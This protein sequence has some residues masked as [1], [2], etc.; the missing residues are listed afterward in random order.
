M[1]CLECHAR[2]ERLDSEHLLGCCGLTL[3]EYALR[4]HRP[5]ELLLAPDQVGA[6]DDPAAWTGP[7]APPREHARA[8]LQGLR[9]AGLLRTEGAFAVIPG[10]VRR[11]DLL[12]W[13]LAWLRDF[14][15]RF[16]QEYHYEGHR[17]MARNRL[18]APAANLRR[19]RAVQLSPVPPPGFRDSLAVY[20]AHAAEPQAGYLFLP[21]PDARDGE[22]VA[23]TLQRAHGVALVRLD[24][25]DH[26]GGVLLRTRAR[27]DGER[28]LGLLES[29]LREMPGA[30]ERFTDATP[31]LAVAKELVFD[32]AHFITDHP[33]KCSN[34]HGGRYRLHVEIHGRVDPVTGCV[35]D[36]G[37]LKRVVTRQVVERFD[38]HT[39]NYADGALAWRSSTEL[40]CIH[41]WERLIDYL[42]GLRALTLYETPQSWCTYRGP[43]L[44][45]FQAEGEAALLGHFRDP[46][47]GRSPLRALAAEPGARLR[48]VGEALS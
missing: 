29:R 6:E 23:E 16:R 12:F 22:S 18:K 24:A 4:H 28:L 1:Q 2:L 14:G 26:P 41:I 46:A 7:V 37:Y 11:L 48:V 42:P 19:P 40:L 25:A 8:V 13:D 21:F 47:L 45:R 31:E 27:A 44:A 17:V 5:L 33:A 3:Q 39:L 34:L 43:D 38:H 30:W 9:W 10:E 15:F 20:L 36:Y 35:V 32:A